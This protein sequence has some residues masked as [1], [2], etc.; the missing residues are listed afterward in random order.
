MALIKTVE[1][2]LDHWPVGNVLALTEIHHDRGPQIHDLV[3]RSRFVG[4]S[5]ASRLLTAYDE[6]RELSP[7]ERERLE[8]W[9]SLLEGIVVR[10]ELASS[11]S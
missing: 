8:L 11:A 1:A 7:L 5:G 9:R 4:G 3:C 6:F 2:S 10:G